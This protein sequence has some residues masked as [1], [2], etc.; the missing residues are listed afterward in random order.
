M[1]KG[2]THTF[3]RIR[4]TAAEMNYAQRRVIEVK[5]GIPPDEPRYFTIERREIEELEELYAL[6][7]AIADSEDPA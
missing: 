6:E 5:L 2:A 7:P 1:S 3:R 4:E